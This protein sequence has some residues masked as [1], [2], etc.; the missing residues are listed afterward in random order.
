LI[1]KVYFPREMLPVSVVLS[2]MVNFLLS[3]PALFFFMIFLRDGLPDSAF[4][5][6]CQHVCIDRNLVWLPLLIVTQMLFLTGL[7]FLLRALRSRLPVLHARQ[8]ELR[9]G[10]MSR[11][12]GSGILPGIGDRGS[13]IGPSADPIPDPR[14][15]IPATE[16]SPTP[17]PRPLTPKV[18]KFSHVSK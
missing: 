17:Q 16:G 3:L 9:R 4:D 7:G 8:Q 11:D 12:R 5:A 2:T 14:S 13:G 15:P 10:D 18:I 6:S 1:K